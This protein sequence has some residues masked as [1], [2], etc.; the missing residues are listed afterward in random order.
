MT[1]SYL[2][3]LYPESNRYL[4]EDCKN[5]IV[6]SI[7]SAD[8]K[9]IE[10]IL[11]EYDEIAFKFIDI[12]IKNVSSVYDSARLYVLLDYLVTRSRAGNSV[13]FEF[14]RKKSYLDFFD[15]S[16][17]SFLKYLLADV[18]NSNPSNSRN[19]ISNIQVDVV[20]GGITKIKEYMLETEKLKQLRGASA[21]IKFANIDLTKQVVLSQSNLIPECIVYCNGG[22]DLLIVPAGYGKEICKELENKYSQVLLGGKFAFEYVTCTLDQALFE[23][24]KISK[25]VTDKLSKRQMFK[26]YP[27][28]PALSIDK[29]YINQTELRFE[30]P[31]VF[32]QQAVVCDTCL[33]RDAHYIV[34]EG[35]ETLHLCS[36]CYLKYVVGMKIRHIFKEEYC[37]KKNISNFADIKQIDS[38]DEIGDYIAIIYGDG[39]NMGN[40]V[41]N[42]ENIVQ[43]TYF[44]RKLDRVTINSV[45]DAIYRYLG[46][47]LKFETVI[48]GGDDIFIIVPAEYA[49]D[50]A[51]DIITSFDSAFSNAITMSVGILITKPTVPIYSAFRIVSTLLKRAK[52][53][54]KQHKIESGSVDVEVLTGV[55]FDAKELNKKVIFPC[56]VSR[57][58]KIKEAILSIKKNIAT[59]KIYTFKE[60]SEKLLPEEF[61]LYYLFSKARDS[62]LNILDSALEQVVDSRRFTYIAGYAKDKQNKI[63]SPWQEI[64][65]IYDF[66]N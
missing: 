52:R 39:N 15:S 37:T 41:M 25:I 14:D 54:I 63:Y 30:K 53:Y 1:N 16:N 27:T 3:Y 44:S 51:K 40:V 20:K 22:N 2:K 13:L 28:N 4:S 6:Q 5:K 33:I 42:I 65:D 55:N 18:L 23:Y 59:T 32:S 60:A 45:Y 36:V 50:I 19:S 8:E 7:S 35:V 43:M 34:Y 62:K 46:D 21:L 26:I 12:P 61:G 48:L 11:E 38:I 58:E 10:Q 31:T 49:I 29:L 9:T 64:V 56:E 17:K 66:I 24:K 47:E 57:L